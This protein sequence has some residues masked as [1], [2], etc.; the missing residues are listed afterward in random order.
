MYDARMFETKDGYI[1]SN[2]KEVMN[3][4]GQMFGEDFELYSSFLSSEKNSEI[5]T[6]LSIEY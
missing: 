6:A 4:F 2:K 3:E 5:D 1:A